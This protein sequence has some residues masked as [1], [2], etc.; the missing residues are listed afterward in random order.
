MKKFFSG[1][2]LKNFLKASPKKLLK[3]INPKILLKVLNFKTLLI[4][5]L[6]AVVVVL[7]LYGFGGGRGGG[8]GSGEGAGNSKV[9]SGVE[10]VDSKS[11]EADVIPTIQPTEEL[12]KEPSE[13]LEGTDVFEGAILAITV[14]GNDY[15]YNNERVFLGD[16]L[17]I[18]DEV[19]GKLV[20]EVKDDNAS[21]KAYN[22]LLDALDE[23]NI[24]YVEK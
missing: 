7:L 9:E 21:F 22:N 8:E 15:F 19:E 1:L 24:D 6:V 12:K 11:D 20:V 5:A 18:V 13:D 23:I 3:L 2:K 16:F 17:A 14:V 10:K 4:V